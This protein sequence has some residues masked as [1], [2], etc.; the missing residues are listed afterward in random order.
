MLLNRIIPHLDDKLLSNQCGFR[1]KQSTTEQI[2]A[3]RR[4]IEGIGDKSPSAVGNFH[5]FQESF[6]HH[7]SRQHDQDP[8]SLCHPCN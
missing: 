3:L 2:L 6:R 7:P 5:C 4:I 8:E 1:E